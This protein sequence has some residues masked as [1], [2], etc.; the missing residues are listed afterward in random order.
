MP[1][2]RVG[3]EK[4]NF[5]KTNIQ[6]FLNPK[7]F[8]LRL[9]VSTTLILLCACFINYLPSTTI[10]AATGINHQINFQGKLVNIDGTNVTDGSYSVVFSI[11]NVA[12]AGT[13]I[14]TE[15]QTVTVG[16]GIFQVN[17]GSVTVLPGTV[18]FNA[19]SIYLGIKVGGRR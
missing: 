9:G 4:I 14:W 3:G 8:L 5:V 2:K 16:N 1:Q 17:L 12:S 10:Y 6:R 19:D 7:L 15:T 13:N 11:Y 18:D